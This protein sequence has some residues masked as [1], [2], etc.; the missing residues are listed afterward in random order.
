MNPNS[1][2]FDPSEELTHFHDPGHELYGL[3]ERI[4]FYLVRTCRA[5]ES[6]GE[7]AFFAEPIH[8]PPGL[9]PSGCWVEFVVKAHVFW[10]DAGLERVRLWTAGADDPNGL[11]NRYLVWD[12]VI[13]DPESWEGLL[14]EVGRVE[15][16]GVHVNLA[17]SIRHEWSLWRL[18]Q[19]RRDDERGF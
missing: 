17:D 6:F 11:R 14:V 9:T 15:K 8:A 16:F 18:E 3:P 7:L 5:V 10:V 2:E 13:D 12:R 4:F 19:Q 1:V